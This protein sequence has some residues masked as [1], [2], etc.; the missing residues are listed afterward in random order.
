ME[1]ALLFIALWL[2]LSPVFRHLLHTRLLHFVAWRW[3]TDREPPEC[4]ICGVR[5]YSTKGNHNGT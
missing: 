2:I 3:R 4:S 1:I 5:Q